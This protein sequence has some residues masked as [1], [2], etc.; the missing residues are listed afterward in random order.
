[1][2]II[3][4]FPDI[5]KWRFSSDELTQNSFLLLNLPNISKTVKTKKREDSNDSEEESEEN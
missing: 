4:V 3:N 1:M 5:S 2:L